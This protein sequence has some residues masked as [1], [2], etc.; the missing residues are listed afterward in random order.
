MEID[1]LRE[2]L[3]VQLDSSVDNFSELDDS[4]QLALLKSKLDP[5]QNLNSI[6]I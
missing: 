5:A 1:E 6:N 2:I 4:V 3:E